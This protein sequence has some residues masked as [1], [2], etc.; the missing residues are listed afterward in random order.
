MNRTLEIT[1]SSIQEL[2]IEIRDDSIYEGT[3]NEQFMALASLEGDTFGGR[4]R[5]EPSFV[6]ISIDE[7]DPRQ[8]MCLQLLLVPACFSTQWIKLQTREL[9]IIGEMDGG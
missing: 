8:G 7:N 9:R 4:V 5:L 1:N 2:L 3:I 6:V